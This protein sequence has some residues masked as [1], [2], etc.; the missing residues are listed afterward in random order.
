[1]DTIKRGDLVELARVRCLVIF[2]D[3]QI[4]I[5]SPLG[6]DTHYSFSL[7]YLKRNAIKYA[8]NRLVSA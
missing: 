5:I 1:M 4:A 3:V 8:L 2:V 7:Q 6:T